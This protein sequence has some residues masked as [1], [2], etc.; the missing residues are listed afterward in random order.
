[1][2]LRI[3]ID[4]RY[5][6][7]RFPGLG[8]YSYSLVHALGACTAADELLVL[9]DPSSPNTR[10]DMAALRALSSVR[11]LEAATSPLSPSGQWRLPSSLAG[12]APDVFHAP[13]FLTP[14][15]APRPTVAT[16]HDV[17]PLRCPASLPS[18]PKRLL[19][20]WALRRT[21]QTAS[22]VL[23]PSEASR[24]DLTELCGV[25]AVKIHLAPHGVDERFRP[26][27]AAEIARVR[28]RYGLPDRYV[29][30][31]GGNKPHKNLSRLVDAWAKA[32][33]GAPDHDG[34]RHTRLVVA[35]PQ[36]ARFPAAR[37]RVR[38][39][40][41]EDSVVATGEVAEA[42]LPGLYAGAA[43]F[44]C[45]SLHEGFGLPVLEAMACGTPVVC[46]SV[47]AL[48]EVAG[49]AAIAV[50]P[51]DVV[52]LAGA[53]GHLLDDGGA[54]E[55]LREKG[56]TRARAFSWRITAAVTREVYRA[57]AG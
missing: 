53:I 23:V 14:H 9:Y 41:L 18:L 4:G 5:I 10:H 22:A 25:P 11:L 24:R 56:L 47:G 36:D 21:C 26:Q 55:R 31:I 6:Q 50:D 48:R 52:G 44:V 15:R 27:A 38:A 32:S 39:L 7:D 3:A 13:H 12:L 16:V 43:L 51:T 29:L 40:G 20:R 46:S 28:H 42:D 19:F 8:R 17:I 2:P 30:H 49:D 34:R 1:M 54:R 45:P 35:G 57:V 33:A 37:T